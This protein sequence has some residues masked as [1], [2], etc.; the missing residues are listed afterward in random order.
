MSG[1]QD[2]RTGI[3]PDSSAPELDIGASKSISK[4][5]K[6]R[7][8]SPSAPPDSGPRRSL[9]SSVRLLLAL[10]ACLVLATPGAAQRGALVRPATLQQ[11]V[12]QSAVILRGHVVSAQV[13]PHP[14]LQKLMTVVVTMKVQETLKGQVGRTFSFRQFIWDFR[15]IHEA[16]GY[17]KGQELLLLMNPPTRYGLSSPVGL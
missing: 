13:E 3:S 12:S 7:F 4:C 11:L 15:D 14:D 1:S 10:A 9:Q 17:R 8:L 16:A 5:A 2:S 6:H